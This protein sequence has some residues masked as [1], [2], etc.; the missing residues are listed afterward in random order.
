MGKKYVYIL[1]GRDKNHCG[2]SGKV[3]RTDFDPWPTVNFRIYYVEITCYVT[4]ELVS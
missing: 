1:D 3:N 2:F 4:K